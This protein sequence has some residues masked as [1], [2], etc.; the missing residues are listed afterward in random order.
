VRR[1]KL[2]TC[3]SILEILNC[4]G[5]L[6]ITHLMQKAD[7][8]FNALKG[9]LDFLINQNMIE[10][11]VVDKGTIVY[12]IGSRGVKLLRFFVNLHPVIRTLEANIRNPSMKEKKVQNQN[13]LNN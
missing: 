13:N 4:R 11:R 2:E 7:L 9:Q 12:A 10:E 3:L 1:S 8:N 6:K 5:P